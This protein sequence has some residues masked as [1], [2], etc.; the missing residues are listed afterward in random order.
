MTPLTQYKMVL[1][2]AQTVALAR[3][4]AL[5]AVLVAWVAFSSVVAGGAPVNQGVTLPVGVQ[6]LTLS[7][8][9]AGASVGPRARKTGAITV[10]KKLTQRNEISHRNQIRHSTGLHGI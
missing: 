8:A 9:G 7:A 4:V 1:V 3:P 5:L 2:A 6:S 10:W